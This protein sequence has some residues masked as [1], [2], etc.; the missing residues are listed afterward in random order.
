[1]KNTFESTRMIIE[2]RLFNTTVNSRK[3]PYSLTSET[4]GTQIEIIEGM[5]INAASANTAGVYELNSTARIYRNGTSFQQPNSD[6]Y[7]V[8][9]IEDAGHA[10]TTF[11]QRSG[12]ASGVLKFRI[13]VP[14]GENQ[15]T[16]NARLIA[17][18]INL[19]M[20]MTSGSAS[21]D[22]R[23]STGEIG[24]TLFIGE[25][26]LRSISKNEDGYLVYD[27]DFIYDYYD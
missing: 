24:G 7:V 17:D 27:L 19:R 11:G 14:E 16:R 5:T 6:N 1:M 10:N 9:F 8:L 21:S 4:G 22:A 25:G 3:H 20:G 13:N 18:A 23:F 15:S 12:K 2:E 26:S